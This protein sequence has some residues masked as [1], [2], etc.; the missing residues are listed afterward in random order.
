M[1]IPDWNKQLYLDPW[2]LPSEANKKTY[3]YQ[4]EIQAEG[5]KIYA[6]LQAASALP[7][8]SALQRN[9]ELIMQIFLFQEAV[10]HSTNA[11]PAAHQAVSVQLQLV[12]PWE[13]Q[14]ASPLQFTVMPIVCI[15]TAP[16]LPW[17]LTARETWVYL[18]LSPEGASDMRIIYILVGQ[19]RH[20]AILMAFW[21]VSSPI[22]CHLFRI[23]PHAVV[24]TQL[25]LNKAYDIHTHSLRLALLLHRDHLIGSVLGILNGTTE[26]ATGARMSWKRKWEE[27]N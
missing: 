23:S 19:Q 16:F 6:G 24:R 1:P 11:A 25:D 17:A 3:S 22:C 8:R 12:L 7:K 21:D 14:R 15:S 9:I 10:D 2:F 27:I 13:W 5:R 26:R 4:H 18:V 20:I